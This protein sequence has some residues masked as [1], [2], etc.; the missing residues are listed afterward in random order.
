MAKKKQRG[1]RK[2]ALRTPQQ[3]RQTTRRPDPVVDRAGAVEP[4]EEP[5]VVHPVATRVMPS[6]RTVGSD[7]WRTRT[8]DDVL[9]LVNEHRRRAGLGPLRTDDRLR[10]SARAHSA[11]MA[12]R[13]Y[14]DHTDPD[15]GNPPDRMR[16]AG[17]PDPAAE[18]LARGQRSPHEVVQ[19]WMNS[20]GH[21]KNIM[22][23]EVTTL[24]VGIHLG[25]GGP[26]WTQHFGY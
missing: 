7:G 6:V 8:E 23:P 5:A 1:N 24:G 14:F 21:R 3:R 10:A 4:E 2:P 11:D 15:G 20:P 19:A 22:K 16:A 12:R 18:N 17:Y 13:G 9:A 26:W 25:D